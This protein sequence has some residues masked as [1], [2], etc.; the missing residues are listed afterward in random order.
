M[1]SAGF[2]LIGP[3][4]RGI[5]RKGKGIHRML[6]R[7]FALALIFMPQNGFLAQGRQP[8]AAR[9]RI[10]KAENRETASRIAVGLS[11]LR[12]DMTPSSKRTA[13]LEYE[14]GSIRFI[15]STT[16]PQGKHVFWLLKPDL[17]PKNNDGF[18][19]KTAE[20]IMFEDGAKRVVMPSDKDDMAVTLRY[21]KLMF[22][23]APWVQAL[24]LKAGP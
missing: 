20:E 4:A 24:T 11:R 22:P 10:L 7:V 12:A 19:A 9:T 15:V 5:L 6:A 1:R 21:I 14:D 3:Q 18:V 2:H 8:T 23:N 17:D 16:D 13:W